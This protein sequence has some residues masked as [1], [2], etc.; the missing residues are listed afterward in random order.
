V[1]LVF[2]CYWS[3]GRGALALKCFNA[4][5]EGTEQ[6]EAYL[7]HSLAGVYTRRKSAQ[8]V[9]IIDIAGLTDIE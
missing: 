6:N 3:F 8:P 4:Y 2:L 5:A 1:L 7:T 9:H